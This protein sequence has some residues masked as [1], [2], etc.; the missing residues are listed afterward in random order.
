M[1]VGIEREHER[2]RTQFNTKGAR[3]SLES[4]PVLDNNSTV[5]GSSTMRRS[6]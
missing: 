5:S 4:L 3:A 2:L 1:A 6:E